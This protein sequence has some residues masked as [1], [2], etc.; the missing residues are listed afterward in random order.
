MV[1]VFCGIDS[2]ELQHQRYIFYNNALFLFMLSLH[3]PQYGRAA[4]ANAQVLQILVLMV[5]VVAI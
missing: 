1:I 4:H 5:L 2:L 3:S